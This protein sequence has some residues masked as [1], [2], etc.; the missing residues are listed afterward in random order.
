MPRYAKMARA[1]YDKNHDKVKLITT[2][3]EG[4][5]KYDK[6]S[7]IVNKATQ[8]LVLHSKDGNGKIINSWVAGS[9]ISKSYAYN[10]SWGLWPWLDGDGA[11]VIEERGV[12]PDTE[13]RIKGEF[14]D[15]IWQSLS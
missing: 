6:G 15:D 4:I 12:F 13:Y 11:G 7:H 8:V 2:V 14:C 10:H 9:A 3:W 1:K 5:Q